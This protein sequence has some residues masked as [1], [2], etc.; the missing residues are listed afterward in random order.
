MPPNTEWTDDQWTTFRSWIISHLQVGPVTVTFNKKDGS[1]RVMT[2]SLQPE[3]LPP[4]T[5]KESNTN[6][7]ADVLKTHRPSSSAVLSVYDLEAN[8]WRSFT[9]KN[10]TNVTLKLS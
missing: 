7:P 8:A 10:V 4:A 9:V 2:C 1:E 6:N 5:I 3:L